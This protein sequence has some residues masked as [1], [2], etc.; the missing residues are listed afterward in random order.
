MHR[1]CLY[2]LRIMEINWGPRRQGERPESEE[3]KLKSEQRTIWMFVRVYCL[4]LSLSRLP[5]IFS[6][7]SLSVPPYIPYLFVLE[8]CPGIIFRVRADGNYCNKMKY[9]DTISP[10]QSQDIAADFHRLR[11]HSGK[12][13]IF[14]LFLASRGAQDVAMSIWQ[15]LAT[16]STGSALDFLICV[17]CIVYICF[18]CIL[19]ALFS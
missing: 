9:S 2:K 16:L 3:E 18:S 11:Q 6:L 19:Y 4:T 10:S 17:I 1:Q 14:Y 13:H 8:A 15:N 7:A 5:F 12:S